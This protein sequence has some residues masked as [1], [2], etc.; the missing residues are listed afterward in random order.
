MHIKHYIYPFSHLILSDRC[1][2]PL[3]SK[4]CLAE[5]EFGTCNNE[6]AST[7][8]QNFFNI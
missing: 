2:R 3:S 6:S 8:C 1:A 5:K 4:D 7:D